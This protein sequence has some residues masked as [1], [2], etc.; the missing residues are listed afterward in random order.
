[1]EFLALDR[2][3]FPFFSASSGCGCDVGAGNNFGSP[4]DGGL[5]PIIVCLLDVLGFDEDTE[6]EDDDMDS[7]DM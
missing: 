3:N 1:V 2:F 4:N 7:V 5:A 6:E